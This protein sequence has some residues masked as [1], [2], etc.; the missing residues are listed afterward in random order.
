MEIPRV[1]SVI[2][3]LI[4]RNE[5]N[6]TPFSTPGSPQMFGSHDYQQGPSKKALSK[7]GNMMCKH[8][9]TDIGRP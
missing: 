6:S 4:G 1:V 9:P 8:L 2:V 3:S 7:S 5:H